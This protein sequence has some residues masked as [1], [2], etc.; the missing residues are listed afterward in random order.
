MKTKQLFSTLF[1]LCIFFRLPVPATGAETTVH[2]QYGLANFSGIFQAQ[3][4]K[5]APAPLYNEMYVFDAR[6]KD[7]RIFNEHGME[8][9]YIGEDRDFHNVRDLA[10]DENGDIYILRNA[11]NQTD[12]S[13]LNFRGEPARE[14]TLHDL[15]PA[16]RG[17]SPSSI[18]YRDGRIYLADHD[19]LLVVIADMKGRYLK[20]YT[21]PRLVHPFLDS[22]TDRESL[23]IFG[24]DVDPNG[25]MLFTIP[26]MFSVFRLSEDGEIER[27]GRSGSSPGQFGVVAGVTADERGFY[28]V[29]DRL[30]C[31]VLIFDE[32][33]NFVTEFGYRGYGPGNLIVPDDLAVD[34]NGDIYVS[35][36]GNR[37]VSVFRVN[38]DDSSNL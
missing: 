31:V 28:Y 1:F 36:A 21:L 26:V 34:A 17:F 29:S 9:F 37:G 8:I 38:D 30:R 7:I 3:L 25:N 15:P 23:S 24:F 19:D 6:E 16:F 13:V 2:Y 20:G 27:W 33:F 5:L 4:V 18:V 11:I 12:I 14:F 10:V 35:Q 32:S 22:K